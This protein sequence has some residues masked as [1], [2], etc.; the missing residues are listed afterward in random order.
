MIL[1]AAL[2]TGV[3][4]YLAVGALTGNLPQ[5]RPGVR[6]RS[7]EISARQQWLIQAG[8]ELTPRQFVSGS[9]L[10]AVATFAVLTLLTGTPAVAVV[11]AG[12]VG[13][14]PR[15]YFARLRAARL[16]AVQEAWPDGLRDLIAGISAGLS[17]NRALEGLARGGPEP[18]QRAFARYPALARMLGVVPALEL[19]KEELADPTSDRVIEV[20]ILA[21]ERGGHILGEIL[22]QLADAT[23]RDIR[24]LEEIATDSLEQRINA[25]AVFA[26]PWI[27][28]AVLTL[29]P[30]HFREFYR[31][32]GGLLVVLAGGALS[33]LGTWIVS[34]LARDPGEAR[35]FGGGA[36][37]EQEV[38][39]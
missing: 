32:P 2:F 9:I 26:L 7:R 24:T 19:I 5:L 35:V 22:R 36:A 21:H 27:V 13:L 25:R 15:A 6:R 12:V 30:G 18:L 16:R 38:R 34:R 28:L 33:L 23:T 20:L 10:A 17:L 4:V 11:P 1:L 29:Q 31:T 3:T 39:P 8:A 37:V 14:L